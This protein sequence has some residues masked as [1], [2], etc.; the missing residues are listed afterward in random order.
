MKLRGFTEGQKIQPPKC[1]CE[2]NKHRASI[3]AT[4]SKSQPSEKVPFL[5]RRDRLSVA[6][7]VTRCS[8]TRTQATEGAIPPL[9]VRFSPICLQTQSHS[10]VLPRK[11]VSY[12]FKTTISPSHL[13]MSGNLSSGEG[14]LASYCPCH[15]AKMYPNQV[16]SYP[17]GS[18]TQH[19]PHFQA[20]GHQTQPTASLPAS[21]PA[22][23]ATQPLLSPG[24]SP[25]E[26]FWSFSFPGFSYLL[27][28]I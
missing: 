2:T 23:M 5:V 22:H 18:Y 27:F 13:A 20:T 24:E 17:L 15:G 6:R 14:L 26:I 3:L 1:F 19:C 28:G 11:E 25:T 8:D 16:L 7:V 21:H 9:S 4:I 10:E 12:N